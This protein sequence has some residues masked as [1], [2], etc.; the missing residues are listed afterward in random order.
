MIWGKLIV[1]I[2]LVMLSCYFRMFNF[3]VGLFIVFSYLSFFEYCFYR[4]CW[5]SSHRPFLSFVLLI[6]STNYPFHIIF[7]LVVYFLFLYCYYVFYYLL[8]IVLKIPQLYLFFFCRTSLQ[9]TRKMKSVTISVLLIV[10][11][12]QLV[13]LW[14]KLGT[15]EFW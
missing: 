2:L 13:F 5:W 7:Y 11:C 4:F 10:T 9:S 12:N 6:L 8:A 15:L 14:L 1:W 3:F